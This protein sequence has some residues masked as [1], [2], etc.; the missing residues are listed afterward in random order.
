MTRKWQNFAIM[1]VGW[2]TKL[3]WNP[4]L[5]I[6]MFLE[7]KILVFKHFSHFFRFFFSYEIHDSMNLKISRFPFLTSSMLKILLE[8]TCQLLSKATLSR[9]F[10][11]IINENIQIFLSGKWNYVYTARFKGKSRICKLK[12]ERMIN[13]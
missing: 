6:F 7:L 10:W 11:K 5:K 4:R 1:I 3:L 13:I 8:L 12:Y 9:P 2:R